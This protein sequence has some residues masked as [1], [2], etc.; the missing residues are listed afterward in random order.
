MGGRIDS[1]RETANRLGEREGER[2]T[3]RLI[4]RECERE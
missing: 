3:R 1:D 2:K 4:H